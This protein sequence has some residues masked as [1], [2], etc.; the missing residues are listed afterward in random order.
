VIAII[1]AYGARPVDHAG[2]GLVVRPRLVRVT[3]ASP[4]WMAFAGRWGEDAF[5]HFPNNDPILYGTGPRAPAFHE[6][7]RAPVTEVLSWP[8]G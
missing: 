5:I 2:N 7:W 6:Q 8:R 4:R 1:K 3:A